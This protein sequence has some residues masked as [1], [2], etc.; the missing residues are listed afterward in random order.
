LLKFF[1]IQQCPLHPGRVCGLVTVND[2][3]IQN[4]GKAMKPESPENEHCLWYQYYFRGERGRGGLTENR[5]AFCRLLWTMWS[6]TWEF[7]NDT[8]ARSAAAFDNPD[9][10]DVVIH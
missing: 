3:N 4:I 9:F 10:V 8:F 7:G 5:Q 6:P 2:Y 1:F